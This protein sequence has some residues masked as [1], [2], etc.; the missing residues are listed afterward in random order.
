MTDESPRTEPRI[1]PV[2][3][4]GAS[5]G[6][7]RPLETFF[8]SI[9][10][11]TGAAFVVI[12]H[13][14]PDFESMMEQLLGRRTRMRVVQVTDGVA[15]AADTVYLIP[16]RKEMRLSDGRLWLTDRPGSGTELNMPIDVFFTSMARAQRSRAIAVLLSGAGSDGSKG[17]RAVHDAGGL[18]AVQSPESAQF[19]LM[20]KAAIATGDA[21]EVLDPQDL[22]VWVAR[23]IQIVHQRPFDPTPP[24]MSI[25]P[26]ALRLI[27]R[28][29]RQAHGVD[30]S[31]YK[32]PTL[33]RRIERRMSETRCESIDEYA[34]RLSL[35]EGELDR[36][37]RDLLIGVSAFFRDTEAFDA[38][39]EKVVPRLF[40]GRS[41]TD[42]L[43]V[44]V[45]GCSTG[46][47]AYSLAMLLHEAALG[48]R[49]P[50]DA[51][52][53]FATD[54]HPGYLAR[55][56][57]GE[58]TVDQLAPVPPSLRERYFMLDDAGERYQV[59]AS[60]RATIVFARHDL[61]HDP[62][63]TRIDLVSCRNMLIYLRSAAQQRVLE[64]LRASL[65]G[66]GWMFL[67]PSEHIGALERDFE[68][69]DRRERLYRARGQVAPTFD[70]EMTPRIGPHHPINRQGTWSAAVDSPANMQFV[71][72]QVLDRFV[73]GCVLL[74]TNLHVVHVFGDAARFL[75]LGP[76]RAALDIMRVVRSPLR[77][78]LAAALHRCRE[79]D[80]PVVHRAVPTGDEQRPLIDI[81]VER[82]SGRRHQER[83]YTVVGFIEGVL[84]ADEVSVPPAEDQGQAY[85][86][87]RAELDFTREHLSATTEELTASNEELQATNEELL[88]ANEE[89]QSTN[90]ELHS[91]NEELYTVNSE[92]RRKNAELT[93]LNVDVDNLLK[94]SD[95]GAL[96]LDGS[97]RVRKFTPAAAELFNLLPHDIDRPLGHLASGLT[98]G[99]L[100]ER[101]RD[102]LRTGREWTEERQGDDGRVMLVRCLPYRDGDEQVQGAVLTF[103]DVTPMARAL[104]AQ[105][106]SERRLRL[107]AEHVPFVMWLGDAGSGEFLFVSRALER[108]WG[109]P[110]GELSTLQDRYTEA[111]HPDDRPIFRRT[112][113]QMATGHFTELDYRLVRADGDVVWVRT[114]TFPIVDGGEPGVFAGIT[115]DITERR[116]HSEV[117]DGLRRDKERLA[118]LRDAMLEATQ[119]AIAMLDRSGRLLFGN[120]AFLTLVG[121]AHER[122]EGRP[123][124]DL[125]PEVTAG[126]LRHAIE[127]VLR[128]NRP[129]RG[130]TRADFPGRISTFEYIVSPVRDERWRVG[131]VVVILRD[132]HDRISLDPS[133]RYGRLRE[134][135]LE[136][137]ALLDGAGKSPEVTGAMRLID[138]AFAD[139]VDMGDAPSDLAALLWAVEGHIERGM[140]ESAQLLPFGPSGGLLVDASGHDMQRLLTLLVDHALGDGVGRRPMRVRLRVDQITPP[141]DIARRSRPPLEPG[142]RAWVVVE[143]ADD[144]PGQERGL[145]RRIVAGDADAGDPK[146]EHLVQLVEGFGGAI[147]MR[148]ILGSGTTRRVWLPL[149]DG[150][151]P[152]RQNGRPPLV[153]VADDAADVRLAARESLGGR[154]TVIEAD[155]GTSALAR[156]RIASSPV[157]LVVLDVAMP[158]P[159][160]TSIL[161]ELRALDPELPVV[162]LSAWADELEEMGIED[163]PG[164]VALIKP[165]SDG[166]L[167]AIVDRILERPGEESD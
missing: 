127:R 129:R 153:L 89:L 54:V 78:A 85:S 36:L 126:S 65:V 10:D 40:E 151:S 84:P 79:I 63:F 111:I 167:R 145:I 56:G 51:I 48:H 102:V 3:A 161:R 29:L 33:A 69:I 9:P 72:Q 139:G 136:A 60:L 131:H 80:E 95:L 73:P 146:F 19:D 67:G 7:L 140:P 83:R 18:V 107:F 24:G 162:L 74:D 64:R 17:I 52:K 143:V 149:L 62:P 26:D 39:S 2:V 115:E 75:E 158:G 71:Y 112:F 97:L 28:L 25:D 93:Q 103:S 22:P 110:V 66:G 163:E 14:S 148:S 119:D 132:V 8:E 137:R 46:E 32:R 157:A 6:G 99:D 152:H 106:A 59:R 104:A 120:P 20:P 100:L 31:A 134:A 160:P 16:R 118:S 70:P 135:A 165:W 21:D 41:N 122:A 144:G 49:F 37:Y 38:L 155:D 91:V 47:E 5:A 159:P 81:R 82:L 44:W 92:F 141:V 154:C 105:Q 117:V 142:D 114:R 124:E 138:D 11:D 68:I 30:F 15:I 108:I 96:F 147:E 125:L 86:E 35:D 98:G 150:S 53:V 113:G 121:T 1:L 90:E 23:Q 123:F 128:T 94:G 116:Q 4:L 88:A 27:A 57:K 101:V 34:A 156:F 130:E 45:A 166:E 133:A 87:L 43:R 61:L 50:V 12:Q 76:G 55:A 42:P 164:C 58:Y 109:R 77:G 13:L